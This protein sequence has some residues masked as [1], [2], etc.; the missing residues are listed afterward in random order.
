M[1]AENPK[2][3]PSPKDLAENL[4]NKKG[5][6]RLSDS[7][8]KSDDKE[9]LGMAFKLFDAGMDYELQG[10]NTEQKDKTK[11]VLWNILMKKMSV[12][13]AISGGVKGLTNKITSFKDIF[14]TSNEEETLS[15]TNADTVR[16]MG[17]VRAI[18]YATAME[19][20][21]QGELLAFLKKQIPNQNLL[22][23]I[24]SL[25]SATKNKLISSPKSYEKLLEN[26]LKKG[27]TLE[28]YISEAANE[29]NF[30]KY[31]AET[32]KSTEKRGKTLGRFKKVGDKILDMADKFGMKD[33]LVGMLEMLYKIPGIG[34]IL[35]MMFSE[36]IKGSL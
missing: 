29:P 15:A 16:K 5:M 24:Q 14:S 33:S 34:S 10:F 28:N 12:T 4:T 23:D 3:Q 17:N 25:D 26:G 36:R 18:D 30:E 11:V 8:D 7:I 27:E 35:K 32:I 6:E 9:I 1:G 22:V 31:L 20:T 21:P 2:L 19:G 13:G